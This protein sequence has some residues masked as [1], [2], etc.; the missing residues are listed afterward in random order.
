MFAEKLNFIMQLTATTN[1]RLA[2][3]INVDPSL[4]SKLKS[5]VRT[6]SARS[7]YLLPMASYFGSKCNDSFRSLT[8][9]EVIGADFGEDIVSALEKWFVDD[10]K[11]IDSQSTDSLFFRKIKNVKKDN[12]VKDK[13][14]SFHGRNAGLEA[15]EFLKDIVINS[16]NIKTVK[17]LSNCSNGNGEFDLFSACRDFLEELIENETEV[18]RVLPDYSDL[19]RSVKDV[20][21]WFPLLGKGK[22]KSYYFSGLRDSV[23]NNSMIVVS[24][25]AAMFSESVGGIGPTVVTTEK[26]AVADFEKM[27]DS[28]VSFCTQGSKSEFYTDKQKGKRIIDDFFDAKE[29]C[30]NIFNSLPYEWTPCDLLAENGLK[31]ELCAQ[32]ADKVRSLL[33]TNRVT[34]IFPVFSPQDVAQGKAVCYEESFKNGKSIAYTC[35]QY[36]KHLEAVLSVLESEPNYNIVPMTFDEAFDYNICIKKNLCA[37]K[38][39]EYSDGLCGVINHPLSVCAMWQYFMSRYGSF[40]NYKDEKKQR[41]EQI[42]NL[43]AEL[44]K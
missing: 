10:E 39:P 9:L 31:T 17:I 19:G 41:I 15:V 29:D 22:L 37:I 23:F 14:V 26:N 21:S 38:L 1:S 13:Y 40:D 30:C 33:K 5:G 7:D 11:N 3:A 24:G 12:A 25:V 18:V 20:F 44:N 42:K 4:V 8:L 43:I 35:E 16:E 27:F 6:V 2:A 28:Y 32:R 36:S 34:E